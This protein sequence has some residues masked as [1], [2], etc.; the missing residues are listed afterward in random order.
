MLCPKLSEL[1][2]PPPNKTGWPWTEESPPFLKGDN[3]ASV[4]PKVTIVTPSYNQARYLEETIRS[5]LL[6]GYPNLEYIIIDGGSTDSSVDIIRKYE[7]WITYWVSQPD[8]GQADAINKGF[9]KSSGEFLG[10]INS[11]DFLYPDYLITIVSALQNNPDVSFVYGDVDVGL[12]N[13]N[14]Q[15]RYYGEPFILDEVLKT[16]RLAIPQQG[17]MWRRQV[18]EQVGGLDPRWNV[19]LD[20]EF[21]IRVGGSYKMLHV[22]KLVGFFRLHEN[23]KSVSKSIIDDWL[24]EL[25][26]V[27]SE[28]FNR[29]ELPDVIKALKPRSM[30]AVYTYCSLMAFRKQKFKESF[31]FLNQ[32]AREDSIFTV[33]SYVSREVARKMSSLPRLLALKITSFDQET[34]RAPG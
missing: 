13:K 23:S 9:E 30:V 20:R 32:A 10:W 21:F 29:E 16:F 8:R 6:Q 12:D 31:E 2:S 33:F 18:I 5:V 25:P 17:S 4:Y 34:D 3:R 15:W 11:D 27:Y 22:P 26:L 1:P 7:P 14:I 28:F 24:R 19:A